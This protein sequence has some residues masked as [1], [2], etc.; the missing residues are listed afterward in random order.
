MDDLILS[1]AF[2]K[3]LKSQPYAAFRD[4]ITTITPPGVIA[5]AQDAATLQRPTLAIHG[6]FQNYGPARRVGDLMLELRS[7]VGDERDDKPHAARFNALWTALFGADS[8]DPHTQ[9]D[10]LATAKAALK[11]AL[12]A[13]SSGAVSLADYGPAE[14]AVE[15]TFDGE[16][17]RTTITLRVA[18]APA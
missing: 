16:D 4:L 12:A 11:A 7:R 17:L 3:M 18:W 13:L 9:Q 1:R 10:N 14:K 8:T 2:A 6:Q 15:Q 5:S